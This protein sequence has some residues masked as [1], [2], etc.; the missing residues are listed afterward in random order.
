MSKIKSFFTQKVIIY[1]FIF[2]I[3]FN[4]LLILLN[5]IKIF[6]I[7]TKLKNIS[8][9]ILTKTI[10]Y[11]DKIL[12]LINTYDQINIFFENIYFIS[13]Y[14][15]ELNDYLLKKYYI[16]KPVIFS[17]SQEYTI[18]E[19]TNKRKIN[20][21]IKYI[22]FTY[23]FYYYLAILVTI[24]IS[25]YL[26][27]YVN[28]KVSIKKI[29]DLKKKRQ[30][31][32][33]LLYNLFEPLK[34]FNYNSEVIKIE[35]FLQQYEKFTY[36][37]FKFNL[38]GDYIFINQ[39]RLRNRTYTFFINADAM[40]KS[41]QGLTGI[42]VLTTIISTVIKRTEKRLLE[43]ER[44][45]ETWLKYTC[46]EIEEV[47][48]SFQG[49]MMIS[50][51]SGLIDEEN[52]LFYFINFD[53]PRPILKRNNNYEFLQSRIHKKLGFPGEP[54]IYEITRIP[55][56]FNDVIYVGSDGK[57][58]VLID[59]SM[60][61]DENY[62]LNLLKE[63]KG[64]INT[65]IK[66]LNQDATIIDDLSIIKIEFKNLI[67]FDKIYR[68]NSNFNLSY[69]LFHEW[70]D[71][72]KNEFFQL[73]KKRQYQN[74]VDLFHNLIEYYPFDDDILYWYSYSCRKLKLYTKATEIGERLMNFNKTHKKNIL[75][76]MYCYEKMN[77]I[78]RF[79]FLFEQLHKIETREK[80]LNKIKKAIRK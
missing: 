4:I 63:S 77:H 24:F 62:S 73:L 75:N 5:F 8:E 10:P 45:P 55:L 38:G 39:I 57:D 80:S 30:A 32:Y 76:L 15:K 53:H 64:D 19:S 26:F 20:F 27:Y 66:K 16:S 23:Y 52:G 31:D 46:L 41:L 67:S 17:F 69:Q 11:D 36:K 47:Y 60:N 56:F 65:F 12:Q 74:I 33:Y 49:Y 54:Q 40:G 34:Y 37:S 2:I 21:Q 70:Q 71:Y 13:I 72:L 22:L 50:A 78:F 14:D 1:L 18:T 79:D 25:L 3:I 7:N 51:V 43:K 58:E 48:S 61:E 29:R 28:L 68:F 9:T 35:Y 42:T 44:Y 59:H 6:T